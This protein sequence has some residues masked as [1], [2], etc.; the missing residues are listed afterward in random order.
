[1][2]SSELITVGLVFA[3][4]LL[5][6]V[7]IYSFIGDIWGG[8]RG[9]IRRRLAVE[10]QQGAR[11]PS[12]ALFGDLDEIA[13]R[14]GEDEAT[15]PLT[16]RGRLQR[17]VSQS[18]LPLSANRLLARSGALAA[19]GAVLAGLLTWSWIASLLAAAIGALL[20]LVH[21]LHHR[22]VRLERLQAQLADAFEMMSRVMRAGQ[23]T[24]HAL[25]LVS[26][27]MPEP[28]SGEF[29]NCYEQQNLGISPVVAYRDLAQRTGLFE[30]KMFVVAMLVHREAG[31]NLAELLERLA[32][33]IRDRYRLRG[34]IRSLTAEG[35]FQAAILLALPVVLFGL[36]SLIQPGYLTVLFAYPWLFVIAAASELMGALWIR[37]IVNIDI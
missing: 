33:V 37:R 36:V 12:R 6:V 22:H 4:V 25:R 26:E 24:S 29:G 32:S 28:V 20:P 31:G 14:A 19:G 30:I 15:G 3:V 1:M 34:V 35:R 9:H 5:L 21:V 18:G 13:A 8:A 11:T 16:W 27:E 10:A 17:V 23:S 2:F 7:G